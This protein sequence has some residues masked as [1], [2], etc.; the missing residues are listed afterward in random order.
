[1]FK[2]RQ[3]IGIQVQTAVFIV[4]TLFLIDDILIETN[5][6]F[7]GL[8]CTYPVDGAFDLAAGKS[9][10]ALGFRI[11]GAVDFGNLSLLVGLLIHTLYE[12][13]IHKTDFIAGI[14][15][16]ILFGRIDHEIVP[17]DI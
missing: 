6:S 17:V 9:A 13:G 16:E 3:G 15:A 10:P 11:I 14:K 7:H 4:N 5:L 2:N 1:M 12:I 8:R